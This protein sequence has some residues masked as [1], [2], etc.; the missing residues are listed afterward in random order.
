M[1]IECLRMMGKNN[2]LQKCAS[3]RKFRKLTG[4]LT[5]FRK[6]KRKLNVGS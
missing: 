3:E 2:R 5:Q 1:A 6:L 4:K